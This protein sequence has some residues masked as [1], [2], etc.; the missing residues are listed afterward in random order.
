MRVGTWQQII[1]DTHISTISLI[2]YKIKCVFFR[3][4]KNLAYGRHQLSQSM[5]IEAPIAKKYGKKF[6]DKQYFPFLKLCNNMIKNEEEK[7]QD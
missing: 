3:R 4:E 2:N 5:Q 6:F 7:N 1:N